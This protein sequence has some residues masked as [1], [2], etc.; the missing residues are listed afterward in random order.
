MVSPCGSAIVLQAG[1]ISFQLIAL[2]IRRA[3][4]V[5]GSQNPASAEGCRACTALGLPSDICNA[6]THQNDGASCRVQILYPSFLTP[7]SSFTFEDQFAFRPTGFTTLLQTITNLLQSN[8]FVIVVSL[9]FSK[10]FDTVRHSTLLAKMAQLDL[11]VPVYNWLVDFFQ[12]HTHRTTSVH[13][14]TVKS[15]P[16]PAYRPVSFKG[17]AS[18][19]CNVTK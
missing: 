5:E 17:R 8:A 16:R 18:D 2:Y 14:S 13:G 4:T 12:G 11:P 19:R 1:L 7:P 15:L 6:H 10:A 9:D 3:N